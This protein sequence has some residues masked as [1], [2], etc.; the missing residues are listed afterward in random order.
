MGTF[1]VQI[2]IG[3]VERRRLE[4][5]EALVDTGATYTVLPRS[6]LQELGIVPHRRASFVLADGR[7]VD[8]SLGR[9]W[10][11]LGAQ[12]EYSLVVFGD[13]A[14]LGAVTLEEF[15]LAPDPGAQRLVPVSALMMRIAA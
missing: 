3:D 13:D 9:A 7:R 11:R 12:E 2:D 4:P 8:R 1:R 15:L 5:V 6:L 14:L 10:I